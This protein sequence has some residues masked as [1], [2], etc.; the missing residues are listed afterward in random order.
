MNTQPQVVLTAFW[1][2]INGHTADKEAEVQCWKC[3]EEMVYTPNAKQEPYY[4]MGLEWLACFFGRHEW[5][6]DGTYRATLKCYRCGKRKT[7]QKHY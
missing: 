6:I 2:C 3:G 5:M 4:N 1:Q 7:G